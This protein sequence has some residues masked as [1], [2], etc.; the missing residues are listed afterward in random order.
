MSHRDCCHVAIRGV[1]GERPPPA[2]L[3]DSRANGDSLKVPSRHSHTCACA[4]V[5]S[6]PK[7]LKLN[8]ETLPGLPRPEKELSASSQPNKHVPTAAKYEEAKLKKKS[9]RTYRW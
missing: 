3:L 7:Q 9:M 1:C 5:L 8:T 6:L 2:M 4:A